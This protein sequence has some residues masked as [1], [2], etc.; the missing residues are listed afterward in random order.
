MGHFT[1]FFSVTDETVELAF[2]GFFLFLVSSY[3][4]LALHATGSV[5]SYYG[6]Q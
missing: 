3:V 4:L 6:A 5:N 1:I 2:L